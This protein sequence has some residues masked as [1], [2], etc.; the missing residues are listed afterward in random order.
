MIVLEFF[1]FK[2]LSFCNKLG[3]SE[4][5]IK[6]YPIL[7]VLDESTYYIG[8]RFNHFCDKKFVYNFKSSERIVCILGLLMRLT[9]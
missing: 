3:R 4:I 6:F 5:F 7:K 8:T 2:I 1:N 9:R